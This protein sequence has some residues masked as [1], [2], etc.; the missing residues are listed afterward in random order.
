[1]IGSVRLVFTAAGLLLVAPVL[2]AQTLPVANGR[3]LAGV[4]VVDAL[5]AV[6]MWMDM[7]ADKKNFGLNVQR[8][9]E[10]ALRRDGVQVDRATDNY[11]YCMV[12]ASFD[13]GAVTYVWDIEYYLYRPEGLHILAWTSGGM[14]RIGSADF[15]NGEL[16]AKSCADAFVSEWLKQN[17]K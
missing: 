11:L 1:M 10:L 7:T 8:A 2:S 9:F 6:D 12:S 15:N 14:G 13:R 17:P 4:K 3:A 16:V 5:A